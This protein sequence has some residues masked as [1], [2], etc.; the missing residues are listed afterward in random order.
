MRS[1]ITL[2]DDFGLCDGYIASMKGVILGINPE[3]NIVDI[4]HQIK[5]QDIHQAAFVLASAARC[6]P[7]E[8]IHVAVV[9]PDVG[10]D[11]PAII[12]KTAFGYFVTPDN[13]SLSYVLKPYLVS[14]SAAKS[15]V[16]VKKG[17]KS[18]LDL[19]AVRITGRHFLRPSISNTF[20]GRDIFAPVAAYLSLGK[21]PQEFGE[22]A[23]TIEMLALTS[24][25]KN[26][27]GSISGHIIHIDNF[28]NLITDIISSDITQNRDS[29][30]IEVGSKRIKGIDRTYAEG[31][32]LLAYIG[33]GGY[34][35]IAVKNGSAASLLAVKTGDAVKLCD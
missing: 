21:K 34:L 3:A 13:G 12:A 15:S 8:T 18:E 32:R 4:S 31:E 30:I 35:E 28:G 2:T 17:F 20:H 24:P 29:V 5:P 6:F 10:T 25:Q 7:P 33:S 27:D 26:A 9:D 22:A 1:V 16:F 23:E 19:E 11:R 14:P